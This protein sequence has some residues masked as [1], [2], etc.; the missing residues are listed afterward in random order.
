MILKLCSRTDVRY[1]SIRD[2]HYVE[3]HGC[4]GR[5]LH[6]LIFEN[7][8]FMEQPIGIITGA[9][10]VWACKPRDNFFDITKDNRIEKIGTIINNTVFRL[11]KNEK[12]FA[13]QILSMW[14]KKVKKDWVD[15]YKSEVIG[16]ETFVFG[17]NRVGTIYKADNWSLVGN[18]KGSAKYK[19]HGAYGVGE[20][21]TTDIKLIFCKKV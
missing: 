13:T 20:R 14:R 2:E 1:K 21:K 19:P 10:A 6:Y 3:N 11:I 16:F 7:N 15:R 5:Q 9:S 17:E 4:I 18:T 12:N 8:G